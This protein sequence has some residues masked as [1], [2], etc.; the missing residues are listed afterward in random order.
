[1]YIKD[2][3]VIKNY[4]PS[5]IVVVDDVPDSYLLNPDNAIPI[6]P[7]EGIIPDN[8]LLYLIETLIEIKDYEDVRKYIRGRYIFKSSSSFSTDGFI[9]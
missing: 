2:I 4:Q 5:Q 3:R 1:M 9:S 7:F 6:I 8:H